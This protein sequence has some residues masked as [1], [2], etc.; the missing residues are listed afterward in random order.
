MG[1]LFIKGG[2]D[3]N[4]L[5]KNKAVQ[6]MQESFRENLNKNCFEFLEPREFDDVHDQYPIWGGIYPVDKI[7]CGPNYLS[8]FII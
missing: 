3:K 7:Q 5:F 6:I 1:L 2:G 8:I 4:K